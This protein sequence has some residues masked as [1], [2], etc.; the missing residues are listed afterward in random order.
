MQAFALSVEELHCQSLGGDVKVVEAQVL[1]CGEATFSGS[2]L[3]EGRPACPTDDEAR[4][5]AFH[6]QVLEGV[7]VSR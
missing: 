2:Q 6:P 4:R 3:V 5:E 7:I 1:A